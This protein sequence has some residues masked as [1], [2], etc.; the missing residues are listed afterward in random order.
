[1]VDGGACPPSPI[2]LARSIPAR[3]KVHAVTN[4]SERKKDAKVKERKHEQ[5]FLPLSRNVS[6]HPHPNLPEAGEGWKKK[7]KKTGIKIKVY[8]EFVGKRKKKPS[9]TGKLKNNIKESDICLATPANRERGRGVVWVL[10]K[11]ST[12]CPPIST[13][14]HGCEPPVQL[15]VWMREKRGFLRLVSI[16]SECKIMG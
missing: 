3:H 16:V 5:K 8:F 15:P 2:S 11:E 13:L 6:H 12:G 10:G 9:V 14:V 1:M 7:K 4:E